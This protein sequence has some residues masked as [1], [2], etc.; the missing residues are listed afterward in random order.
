MTETETET[1][2]ESLRAQLG[3]DRTGVAARRHLEVDPRTWRR[4]LADA[5]RP[6]A[7][8]IRLL[9]IMAGLDPEFG[10]RDKSSR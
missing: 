10:P 2:T 8:V 7:V 1:E 6:P 4:W 3:W 5:P 9:R